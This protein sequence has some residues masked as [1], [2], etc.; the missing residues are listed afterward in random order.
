MNT[1]IVTFY[2]FRSTPPERL[3]LVK[4]RLERDAQDAGIR[5]LTIYG[6]EGINATLSGSKDNLTRFIQAIQ[7]LFPLAPEDLKWS[8]AN[9]HPF[10]FFQVKIR[11]EIVT[12][13]TPDLVPHEPI[14]HHLEPSEFHKAL[15]DPETV[16]IDTRNWYE[17]EMGKFRRAIDPHIK[18]FREFPEFVKNSAIDKDKKVLIYCTGGIRCEKAILEMRRQGYQNVFQLKGGILR[19]LEQFPNQEFEGDCFVFDN[20]IAVDQNLQP[21][22]RYEFCEVCG[23]AHLIGQACRHKAVTA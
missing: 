6:Q 10:G 4:S 13:G 18:E 3:A 23:Q 2:Q 11:K 14:D 12:L 1:Q 17:T 16:V 19:Y 9:E 8:T 5:G 7:D 21:A 20:R 15:Q 22:E